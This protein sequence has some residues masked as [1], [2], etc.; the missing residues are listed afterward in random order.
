[1]NSEDLALL[2]GLVGGGFGG[3]FGSKR[4]EERERAQKK[5]DREDLAKFE[6]ELAAQLRED[7]RLE[8]ETAEF[9]E[10]GRFTEGENRGELKNPNSLYNFLFNPS[11]SDPIHEMLSKTGITLPGDVSLADALVGTTAYDDPN[12]RNQQREDFVANPESNFFN[13]T[14]A[15]GLG[16]LLIPGAGLLRGAGMG[17]KGAKAFSDSNLM[18][19]LMNYF[20]RP[21]STPGAGGPFP[22]IGTSL[23]PGMNQGG[24][25][26][27]GVGGDPMDMA[28]IIKL[29]ELDMSLGGGPNIGSAA[30][31]GDAMRD[32]GFKTIMEMLSE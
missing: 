32:A 23:V 26:G 19:N 4:K 30:G 27:L 3:Y 12:I 5:E 11:E 6:R 1:M 7:A 28:D 29:L 13:D 9:K 21:S 18:K 24:R 17:V 16:S 10:Q 14:G 20:R 25:V 2:L 8:K 31:S 15:L 22:T